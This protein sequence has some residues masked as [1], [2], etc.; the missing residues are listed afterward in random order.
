MVKHLPDRKKKYR[1]TALVQTG[2]FVEFRRS[3]LIAI[4]AN[5]LVCERE[6]LII[7]LPRSKTDQQVIGLV[8]V[9]ACLG[10]RIEISAVNPMNVA[11]TQRQ[12]SSPKS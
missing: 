1:D 6:G 3:E 11:E 10:N 8:L 4:K 7:R 2:F 9:A 12:T 5:D